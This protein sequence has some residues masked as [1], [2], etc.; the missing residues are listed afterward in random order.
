MLLPALHV[1]TLAVCTYIAAHEI[2]TILVTGWI[3]SFTGI[4]VLVIGWRRR[5]RWLMLVGCST[6]LLAISLFLLE[7]F[8]LQWGPHKAAQ[9]FGTVFIIQQVIASVVT[10]VQINL[11]VR[12]EATRSTPLT[13]QTLLV[14][15]VS[16][17]VF[18]AAAKQLLAQEHNWIMYMSLGLMGLTFVGL[19]MAGYR[20]WETKRQLATSIATEQA[21][22]SIDD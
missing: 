12:D 22:I 7:A 9:P 2:E 10:L 13:I 20:A 17:S 3:C 15:T 4:L 11:F 1:M 21:E 16:F 19:T 18:F 14:L 5:N 8:V 6:P